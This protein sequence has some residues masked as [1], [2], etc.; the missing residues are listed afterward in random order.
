MEIVQER[1]EREG[2]IEIVQTAPTVTYE[3]GDKRRRGDRDPQPRRP[4]RPGHIEEI[5]E[6]IVKLEIICPTE[7]SA[8]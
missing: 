4:A 8:T 3:V 6:P 1:L 2:D 5:R 7:S